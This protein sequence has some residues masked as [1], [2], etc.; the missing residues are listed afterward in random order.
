VVLA[1]HE[2]AE[3][4]YHFGINLAR[5]VVAGGRVVATTNPALPEPVA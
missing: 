2:Y 3:I 1:A 4:P 5:T